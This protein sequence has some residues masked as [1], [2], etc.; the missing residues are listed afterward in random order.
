MCGNFFKN[1]LKSVEHIVTD[2]IGSITKNLPTVLD[3]AALAFQPE[4]LPL[5][6]G[7][8]TAGSD[9]AKGQSVGKAL[10]SGAVSGIETLAGQEALGSVG[11]GGG[12]SYLNDVLGVDIS[13]AA[14]GLPDIGGSVASLV[15]SASSGIS[16]AAND[17]ATSI[18]ISP[19]QAQDIISTNS[20][21]TASATN[22][23]T[24]L[25]GNV[26][27]ISQLLKNSSGFQ[28]TLGLSPEGANIIAQATGSG[29]D[30]ASSGG[31]L[32]FLKK[33]ASLLLPA[34]SVGQS[35]VNSFQNPKGLRQLENAGGQAL[36][37]VNS[38]INS[39]TTG[40]L[41]PGQENIVQQQLNDSIS[42]IKSHYAQLGLSGSSVENQ[43]IQQAQNSA[44][45]QRAQLANQATQTGLK[46]LDATDS[47]YNNIM[48]TI[49]NKDT[50]L[51]N[52]LSNLASA[53]VG[54]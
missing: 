18:G 19:S 38:L 49:L 46:A 4:L 32:D 54:V 41:P 9:I 52:S 53:S 23:T 26:G 2:P 8:G 51:S 31:V 22:G 16:S 6:Q 47:I 44:I 33:N 50:N 17:L 20:P 13:P 5:A 14:T 39:E 45:Q 12:N 42:A 27:S 48:Q 29:V 28:N 25:G 40:Q 1:P 30:N 37:T 24:G 21:I 43:A 7:V 34:A 3:S 10:K 15:N 35:V 11:I 36:N